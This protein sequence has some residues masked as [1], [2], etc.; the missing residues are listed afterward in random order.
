MLF[1][2]KEK[3]KNTLFMGKAVF[4]WEPTLASNH[5]TDKLTFPIRGLISKRA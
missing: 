1:M 2:E 4:G 3:R 5:S